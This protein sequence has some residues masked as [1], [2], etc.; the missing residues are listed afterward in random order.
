M[1]KQRLLILALIFGGVISLLF[2]STL[3]LPSEFRAVRTIKI[4]ASPAEISALTHNLSSWPQWTIWNTTTDSTVRFSAAGEAGS[5]NQKLT[6]DGE[7]SGKGYFK[8]KNIEFEGLLQ[9]E[10]YRENLEMTFFGEIRF[11]PL[12][13]KQTKV[14]WAVKTDMPANPIFRVAGLFAEDQFGGELEYNLNGLKEKVEGE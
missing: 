6:W 11:E 12:S 8:I 5:V 10:M 9:Y 3:L 2:F 7:K 14:F 13:P 1:T 4:N